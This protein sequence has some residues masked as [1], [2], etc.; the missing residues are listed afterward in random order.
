MPKGLP[1]P[2]WTI[3]AIKPA[4]D[5]V[6]IKLRLLAAAIK[7]AFQIDLIARVLWQ[8]LRA[9]DGQLDEFLAR[10]IL[11]RIQFVECPLTLA[12]R[13]HQS[14]VLQQ[15]QMCRNTRLPHPCD[16]LE[17]IYRELIRLQQGHNAQPRGIR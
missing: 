11:L 6:E 7:D 2:A 3:D 8:F 14:R 1:R 13:L 10:P 12:P 17:L 16:F 5:L 15:A 4:C 9:S